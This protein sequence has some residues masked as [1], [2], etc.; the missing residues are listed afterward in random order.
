MRRRLTALLLVVFLASASAAIAAT[1]TRPSS[2]PRGFFGIAPQTELTVADARY[3]KAGGIESV[4]VPVSWSSIQPT[5]KGGY[6][7]S[8]L[9][10]TVTIAARAGL[11]VLPFL[12][13]TPRWLTPKWTTLPVQ[14]G[15]ER[16]A[17]AAFLQAAVERYGPGGTF[18]NEHAP[19]VVQYA[20]AIPNPTPIRE[21]Q[22]WN[23]VNFFYFAYPVSPSNYGKLVRISSQAIKAVEPQAK[24]I[25]SGLFGKPT[26]RGARGM[27]ATTFL[28]SFFRVPGIKAYFDGVALHPYAVDTEVLEELV[29]GVHEVIEENHDHVGLYITEMGWGS[30]NNFSQV[31]FDQGSQGQVRELRGAYGYLFENQRRLDL[32]QVYW[33]SWKDV[34][35]QCNFCSSVGLF[36]AGRGFNPKPAWRAFVALTGGKVRP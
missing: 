11:R 36:H 30:E 1:P 10:H 6:N 28:R 16:N 14:T 29:E 27:P 24:V 25:L 20:P 17:W 34:P 21:W 23:E 18:W 3:M 26:A 32:Q 5:A 12:Y 7:W 22:I 9:D 33:F 19:G 4:R 13:S 8:G 2:L 35:D 31:A 15:R